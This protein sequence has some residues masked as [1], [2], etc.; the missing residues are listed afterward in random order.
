MY[1]VHYNNYNNFS[2]MSFLD[3]EFKDD[4]PDKKRFNDICKQIC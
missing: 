2:I 3:S 1:K 4:N